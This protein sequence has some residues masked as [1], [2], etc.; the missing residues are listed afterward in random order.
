MRRGTTPTLQFETEWD[1][2]GYE[3]LLTMS[4]GTEKSELT[5]DDSRLTVDGSTV[6]LSLTQAE[7]LQFEKSVQCQIK[8]KKDGVV[9]ATDIVRVKVLPIL[10]EEVM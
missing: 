9:V 7:T 5:F 1:W 2:T 10:N 4:G 8:G 3:L 6:Y